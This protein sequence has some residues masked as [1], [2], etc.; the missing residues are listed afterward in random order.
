MGPSESQ[1][2][3]KNSNN[4]FL[5]GRKEREEWRD[6]VQ[7]VNWK[8]SVNDARDEATQG[9]TLA[10]ERMNAAL[11][12]PLDPHLG[13]VEDVD[14]GALPEFEGAPHWER[15]VHA[16]FDARLVEEGAMS[17]PAIP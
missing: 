5:S 4:Q 17:A 12:S 15:H 13:S 9:G 2:G 3:R 16:C 1:L 6:T 10:S 8:V 7:E 14:A 11:P